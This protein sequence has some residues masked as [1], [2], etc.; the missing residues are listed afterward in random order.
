VQLQNFIQPAVFLAAESK[1][2]RTF[3]TR[4]A[5]HR[6]NISGASKLGDLPGVS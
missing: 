1:G 3:P 4:Y 5:N 2:Q 6:L